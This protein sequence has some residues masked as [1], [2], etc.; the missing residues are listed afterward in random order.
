MGAARVLRQAQEPRGQVRVHGEVACSEKRGARIAFGRNLEGALVALRHM[1]DQALLLRVAQL[2]I[3]RGTNPFS[4]VAHGAQGSR[5]AGA[6]FARTAPKPTSSRASPSQD[7]PG[8][9]WA[10][11][12]RNW[13]RAR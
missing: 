2:P 6:P 10:S 4:E 12:V 8:R 13:V 11:K 5:C 7:V 1:H 9:R 3:D